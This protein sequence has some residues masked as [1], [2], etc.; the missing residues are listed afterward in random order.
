MLAGMSSLANPINELAGQFVLLTD[1]G[2][3]IYSHTDEQEDKLFYTVRDMFQ[4]AVSNVNLGTLR[5]PDMCVLGKD[6]ELGTLYRF[7]WYT[8]L[9]VGGLDCGF[10]VNLHTKDAIGSM[11]LMSKPKLSGRNTPELHPFKDPKIP[12]KSAWANHLWNLVK[13]GTFESLKKH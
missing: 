3:K 1:D 6:R 10:G 5:K 12:N 9:N 2:K 7:Y 8:G 13:D 4:L 11:W